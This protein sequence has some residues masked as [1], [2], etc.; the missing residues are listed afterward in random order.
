MMVKRAIIGLMLTLT[1]ACAAVAANSAPA[2]TP[3]S[4]PVVVGVNDLLSA[5]RVDDAIKALDLRLENAPQ[6]AQAY[7]LLSRSYFA[8]QKW[9][10][11]IEAGEKAV[12]IAPGNS[13][14]HMWLGRAYG[15][16]ADHS[17]WVTALALAKKTRAEFETAVA[18]NGK[19]VDARSDLAEFYVEAPSFLGGSKE[20]AQAQADQV[21]SLGDEPAALWIV[22]KVA[23]AEKNYP[24]AEQNLRMAIKSS[25]NNPS[26]ILNLASFYRRRGRAADVETTVNEAVQAVT[27]AQHTHVLVDGA[28]L[29]YRAGRNLGGALEMLRTYISSPYHSTEA[30]VFQAYYLQGTILEKLG[31]RQAAAE[32]YRA[33]LS[34]ASSFAPAQSALKRLE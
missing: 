13:E 2:S 29:L 9:D 31:D 18:L 34:L 15:E 26:T 1:M 30:P 24:L 8:M 14:Y 33:A 27:N 4:A 25:H 19:N 12:S 7:N 28:Q 10:R 3:N 20:K 22:S 5:G 11:A 17:S 16:K 21:L 32:R 6:D 23:E